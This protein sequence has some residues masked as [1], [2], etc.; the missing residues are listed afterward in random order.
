MIKEFFRR[1]WGD[2]TGW[3]FIAYRRKEQNLIT[4]GYEYPGQLNTLIGMLISQGKFGDVYFCPHLFKENKRTKTNAV[5]QIKWLWADKDKGN[6]SDLEPKPTICWETSLGRYAALWELEE[7]VDSAELEK[8]NR[9]LAYK[10]SSDK[11][12]WDLTQLLRVPG[13]I[14]FKYDTPYEGKLLWDDGGVFPFS[15]FESSE[16]E[17]ML[18]EDTTL[19]SEL[20]SDLPRLDDLVLSL[21]K[22]I[23]QNA[24]SLLGRKPTEDDDWSETLWRL[25]CTLLNAGLTPEETFV[26][27]RHSPWNKYK[28]DGRPDEHLWA[29]VVK[30]SR[31]AGKK[32]LLQS[33]KKLNWL[34]L[35]QLMSF[36]EKPEWLVEGIWMDKNVGWIAG[37]GKSYKSTIS[38]DLALSIA[39]GSPFLGKFEVLNPGPV[40]MIQEEDPAWRVAHRL[41]A[42]TKAK[43]IEA[44]RFF[45]EQGILTMEIPSNRDVPLFASIG[46]GFTLTDP[47][48]IKAV[49]EAIQQ[50]KPRMVMLDPTFM[51]MPGVDEF[52]A[53]EVTGMLNLLKRWRNEYSCSIALVHHYNKASGGKGNSR[54]YGSMA[55]YAWSENSLFVDRIPDT[56]AVTIE[57]DIKDA[58]IDERL[59]VEFIN[60]DED[61]QFRIITDKPVQEIDKEKKK[62]AIYT[63]SETKNMIVKLLKTVKMDAFIPRKEIMEQTNIS[64]KTVDKCIRELEALDFVMIDKSGVGA[65]VMVYPLPRLYSLELP[66]EGDDD[67]DGLDFKGL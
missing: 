10:T 14:N 18:K 61:Y 45:K 31:E 34:G 47:E 17:P 44:P 49:E 23:P 55:F 20:P 24:W 8:A 7:P 19:V 22:K 59:N 21:G 5:D 15:E 53:G 62:R 43:G 3:A 33:D 4:V 28:R 35:N 40:L 63:P 65:T 58:L 30:A 48:S 38:L 46:G 32:D 27:V 25:E 1:V 11:G 52:K 39:S 50:Y 37:V 13:T 56:N 57:R 29:E 26:L 64:A 41:R 6:L 42:M 2:S 9:L 54:L 51:L 16:E 60:V 66:T 67:N 12:G 36:T